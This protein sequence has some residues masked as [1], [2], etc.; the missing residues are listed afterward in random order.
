M[1]NWFLI[2]GLFLFVSVRVAVSGEVSEAEI[3]GV[4]S[5][6]SRL[7]E[8]LRHLSN[9]EIIPA[10]TIL[11]NVLVTAFKSKPVQ[12]VL[13]RV[14]FR[15]PGWELSDFGK[16]LSALVFGVFL[17][18]TLETGSF[19]IAVFGRGLLVGFAA[20]GVFHMWRQSLRDLIFKGKSE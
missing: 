3:E 14:S 13:Q 9:R 2:A 19:T 5:A 18:G 1:R 15:A 11:T 12:K 10:L 20:I 17:V 8:V 16:S 4:F 6:I 7:P